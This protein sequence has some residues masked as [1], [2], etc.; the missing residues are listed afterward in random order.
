LWRSGSPA[1]ISPR[2]PEYI[3]RPTEWD[4][5]AGIPP[6]YPVCGAGELADDAFPRFDITEHGRYP[7]L[8][9]P[10]AAGC[11]DVEM[12]ALVEAYLQGYSDELFRDIIARRPPELRAF[13]RRFS[14]YDDVTLSAAATPTA[15]HPRRGEITR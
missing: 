4:E 12:R 15:S 6:L 11:L 7:C 5:L 3:D 2:S 14:G 9:A 8:C 1:A 10:N 13:A